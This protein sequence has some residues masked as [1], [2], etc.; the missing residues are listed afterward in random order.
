M[1]FC[2]FILSEILFSGILALW[3]DGHG[4]RSNYGRIRGGGVNVDEYNRGKGYIFKMASTIKQVKI[5]LLLSM[6]L[7][8]GEGGMSRRT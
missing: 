6:S 8:Y 1:Y 7:Q 3:S 2:N 5:C 4:P